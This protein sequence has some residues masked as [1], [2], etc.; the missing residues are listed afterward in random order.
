MVEHYAVFPKVCSQIIYYDR[1]TAN[2]CLLEKKSRLHNYI[3]SIILTI[4]INKKGNR[5]EMFQTRDSMFL[6][7]VILGN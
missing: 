3:S 4:K 5:W 1:E 7:G 2:E 6:V